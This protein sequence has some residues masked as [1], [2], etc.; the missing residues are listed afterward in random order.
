MRETE[1]S[2]APVLATRDDAVRCDVQKGEMVS[3]VVVDTYARRGW[4]YHTTDSECLLLASS[5]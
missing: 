5:I 3:D 1:N 4:R 2:S